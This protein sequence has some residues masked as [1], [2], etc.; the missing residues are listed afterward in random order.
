ML[1]YHSYLKRFT[2]VLNVIYCKI[3]IW[4]FNPYLDFFFI[5][6]QCIEL[7]NFVGSYENTAKPSIRRLSRVKRAAGFIKCDYLVGTYCS[8][9]FTFLS[10]NNVRWTNR[11]TD[12][13]FDVSHEWSLT[14]SW[15]MSNFVLIGA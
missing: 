9:T 5:D 3:P 14:V 13:H 8:F 10:Q 4:I 2:H 6:S 1:G 12:G 7:Q 11:P 15:S